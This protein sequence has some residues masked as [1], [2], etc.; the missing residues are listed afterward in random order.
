MEKILGRM[1]AIADM[2]RIRI[3][4][5]LAGGELCLCSIQDLLGLSPSTVSRH[6]SILRSA[7][8]VIS[9]TEG[10]WRFFSI[11]PGIENS[12]EGHLL[13]WL[14]ESLQNDQGLKEQEDRIALLRSQQSTRCS[15]C[16]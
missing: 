3:L 16:K 7:G 1:K 5:A 9:R 2:Q 4:T 11:T 12:P 15:R 10:K 14:M 6:L 13:G 8:F